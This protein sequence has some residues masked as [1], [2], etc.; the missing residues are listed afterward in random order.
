MSP[1]RNIPLHVLMLAGLLGAAD[2]AVAADQRP[3]QPEAKAAA[4][5][6]PET[7][8]QAYAGINV[9]AYGAYQRERDPVASVPEGIGLV[10]GF[11]DPEGPAVGKLQ[12]KDVL[13]R[14]DDQVLVNAE[15]FRALL[16][17][18]K[19]G[20]TV[21]FVRVRGDDVDTVEI[22]LTGKNVVAAR[23]P[24]AR[25]RSGA[26]TTDPSGAPLVSGTGGI[27][28][29]ING[30]EIDPGQMGVGGPMQITPGG[31]G[32]VI[33]IDP[34]SAQMPAEARRMLEQ[35][36]QRGMPVPPDI[37]SI[38]EPDAIAGG[39][40]PAGGSKQVIVRSFSFGSSGAAST[41]SSMYSDDEGTVSIRKEGDKKFATVK[42]AEGKALFD[43][44][45]STE[46]QLK[47]QP[48]AI[49]N[50]IGLADGR[51]VR[52]PGLPGN[53]PAPSGDAAKATSPKPEAKKKPKRDP[54]EG[55]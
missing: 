46:E 36:R 53:D 19:P 5:A 15:Q 52:I 37:G 20:D 32:N 3:A 49:R 34:R 12:E 14:L 1:I 54:H 39:G 10:I 2:R 51:S 13:T 7:K 42:D 4:P 25:A 43:G 16:L 23:Q 31:Q 9:T 48:E 47:A 27:R 8:L 55:A 45:I 28:I 26:A 41:S 40:N 11:V 33:V 22:T 38:D 17:T 21:K 30:Q 35:M 29:M 24:A 6:Q 44:E 18:R 50:R